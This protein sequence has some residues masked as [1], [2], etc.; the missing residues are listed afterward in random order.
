ML[1]GVSPWSRQQL[2][3]LASGTATDLQPRPMQP[4]R[5]GVPAEL[6]ALVQRSL[7]ANPSLR[8]TAPEFAAA[9][10]AMAETL[11]DTPPCTATQARDEE[12]APLLPAAAWPG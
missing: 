12:T 7:S 3:Q 2:V 10:A 11:D 8:P 1:C 6:E 4:Y 5:R 9:L